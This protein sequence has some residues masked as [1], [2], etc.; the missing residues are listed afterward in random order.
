[1]KVRSISPKS[2]VRIGLLS[3]MLVPASLASAAEVGEQALQLSKQG[4]STTALAV[5]QNSSQSIQSEKIDLQKTL[6]IYDSLHFSGAARK[7]YSPAQIQL[8]D[9]LSK[10]GAQEFVQLKKKFNSIE[11]SQRTASLR[12]DYASS[13]LLADQPKIAIEEM[14]LVLAQMG[15]KKEI[16]G[17]EIEKIRVLLAR[18]YYQQKD[19]KRALEVYSQIPQDSDYWFEV[20]EEKAWS[21]LQ[22][23]EPQKA[24]GQ[25]KT[26]TAEVFDP[27]V[28]PEPYVLNAYILMKLC[29]YKGVFELLNKFKAQFK[30]RALNMQ[31][32]SKTG[33]TVASD[34]ALDLFFKRG[35]A[36]DVG[37]EVKYL[38]RLFFRSEAF[39]RKIQLRNK[40][41]NELKKIDSVSSDLKSVAQSQVGELKSVLSALNSQISRSAVREQV[42]ELA[43]LETQEISRMLQKM[44]I[45]EAESIQRL[46][47]YQQKQANIQGE[48]K[49]DLKTNKDTLVFEATDEVWLDELDKYQVEVKG[50]PTSK[51]ISK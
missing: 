42:R 5:I 16:D 39:A 49:D 12:Y 19:Y 33:S 4:L 46:F 20:L 41:E 27:A 11:K 23:K 35:S 10:N 50:C 7:L 13:A 26:V 3:F 25:L 1:M 30:E 21:Y 22:L 18:A 36:E 8:A 31:K 45:I 17:L 2:F 37:A 51:E 15:S 14:N 34:K 32:L 38:P 24:L 6:S 47:S 43:V 44:H 9:A 48:Y 40:I 28:G 29:D